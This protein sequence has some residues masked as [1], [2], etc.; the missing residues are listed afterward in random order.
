MTT[1]LVSQQVRGEKRPR[2]ASPKLLT[3][4]AKTGR[5]A[6]ARRLPAERRIFGLRWC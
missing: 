1:G 4:L 2:G 5:G 3:L 6:V